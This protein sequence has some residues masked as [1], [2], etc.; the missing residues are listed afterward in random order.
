M[1]HRGKTDFD[2]LILSKDTLF[3]E[4]VVEKLKPLFSNISAKHIQSADLIGVFQFRS[5]FIH[6]S[7]VLDF[8]QNNNKC[9]NASNAFSIIFFLWEKPECFQYYPLKCN[10]KIIDLKIP[11]AKILKE[12]S[13]ILLPVKSNEDAIF[14]QLGVLNKQLSNILQ[15]ALFTDDELDIIYKLKKFSDNKTLAQKCNISIA[16]LKR[17]LKIIAEK[18]DNAKSKSEIINFLYENYVIKP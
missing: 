8:Y 14:E 11:A 5:L 13:Q 18:C 15:T 17:R 1:F 12:V 7:S 4:V 6:Q 9:K 10:F 3:V 16:T 2:V